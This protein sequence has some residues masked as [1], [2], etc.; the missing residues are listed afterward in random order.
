MLVAVVSALAVGWPLFTERGIQAASDLAFQ[1]MERMSRLMNNP[2]PADAYAQV[3]ESTRRYGAYSAMANEFVRLPLGALA[4]TALY[5]FVFNVLLGGTATFKQV[6]GVNTHAQVVSAVGAT[7]SAPVMYF[8]N[9]FT[10]TGPFNLGA[11]AAMVPAGTFLANFFGGIG[12]FT[13]WSLIVTAIGL[14][15]LYRRKAGGIAVFLIAVYL[16]I[17]AGFA[18]ALS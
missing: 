4:Y 17:V 12:L 13:I 2:M 16:V 10:P 14:G 11:F 8:T 6:L 5:W 9:N 1:M 3:A 18:A 15:V 7:V